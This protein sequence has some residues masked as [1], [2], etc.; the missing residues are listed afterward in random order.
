MSSGQRPR[1]P[2]HFPRMRYRARARHWRQ[3]YASGEWMGTVEG[4]PWLPS[5]PCMFRTIGANSW[6]LATLP[7][8]PPGRPRLILPAL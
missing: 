3:R 2:A 1:T 7:V 6:T 4:A 8:L 5:S